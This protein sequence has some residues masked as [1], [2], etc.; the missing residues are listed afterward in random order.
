M[1]VLN[2]RANKDAMMGKQIVGGTF[3][4]WNGKDNHLPVGVSAGGSYKYRSVI[5]FSIDFSS[6]VS[7]TSATLTLYGNADGSNLHCFQ[8]AGLTSNL[9]VSRMTKDWLEGSYDNEGF[10]T[11]TLDYEWDNRYDSYTTTGQA[12]LAVVNQSG[13]G[14]AETIDVTDIVTSWFNG[15]NNYGFMVRNLKEDVGDDNYG[16]QFYSRQA[17]NS[18]YWPKLSIT[19]TTNTP[20]TE[21]T[22]NSPIN[23]DVVNTLIPTLSGTRNDTTDDYITSLALYVSGAGNR[24]LFS[25]STAYSDPG[26]G[27]LRFDNSTL[28]SATNMYL[29]KTD[30]DG[31]TVSA[32]SFVSTAKITIFSAS[33]SS[34]TSSFTR[35]TPVDMGT[36]IKI[37]LSGQLA[38]TK[39]TAGQSILTNGSADYTASMWSSGPITITGSPTTFS[40]LYGGAGVA[41]TPL[42]GNRYWA[43]QAATSDKASSWS[44]TSS[45]YYFKTNT[46]PDA[47]TTTITSYPNNDIT[48]Q[49]PSFTITHVDNDPD[50]TKAYSYRAIIER[51]SYVGSGVWSTDGG[52]DSLQVD[53]SATPYQ[54]ISVTSPV[55]SWGGSYRFKAAT[56]D[57]NGALGS[58]SPWKAFSLHYTAI[59]VD[60]FPSNGQT[61]SLVPTFTASRGSTTDTITSF[62]VQVYSSDLATQILNKTVNTSTYPGSITSGSQLS[63]TYDGAA[64]SA[65]TSYKWRIRA[66]ATPTNQAS[67]WSDWIT[68]TTAATGTPTITSPSG[69]GYANTS[70]SVTVTNGATSFTN[71]KY[72]IYPSTSTDS[73]PGTPLDTVTVG[74]F[75]GVTS[76]TV[77]Y[78]GS[79]LSYGTSYRIRAA[80]YVMSDW[81]PWAWSSFSTASSGIPTL[82][83][84]GGVVYSSTIPW[85]VTTTPTFTI[86]AY[87]SEVIDKMQ[88]RVFN[89]NAPTSPV[90][91]SSSYDV[92]NA[93]S[94]SL[95]LGSTTALSSAYPSALSP[96]NTYL[97][98]A[99]YVN[100][101]GYSGPFS[102]QKS[103]R[104]NAAPSIPINMYP[105]GNVAFSDTLEPTFYATF[106]DADPGDAP[107]GWYISVLGYNGGNWTTVA[108]KSRFSTNINAGINSYAWQSSDYGFQYDKEYRWTCYFSD[109]LLENGTVSSAQQFK[110]SSAPNGSFTSPSGGTVAGTPAT[111]NSVIPT[112]TWSYTGVA[113]QQSVKIEIDETDASGTVKNGTYKSTGDIIQTSNSYTFGSGY[114][115]SGK[116]YRIT[117]TVTNSDGIPDKEPDVRYILVDTNAPAAITGIGADA[118]NGYSI[119]I[120]WDQGVPKSG[121]TFN[122]YQIQRRLSGDVAWKT[123]GTTNKI[124][125]TSYNDYYAGNG[126]TYQY[127]IIMLVSA[128][129]TSSSVISSVEPDVPAI[130]TIDTDAW[131][132]IPANRSKEYIQELNVIDESH[133]KVIQQESF[134]T[135]GSARKLI[136]R[137]YV[138]GDEGSITCM[139][140]NQQ[141]T[142]PSNSS[143]TLNETIIGRR[144]LDYLTSNAGPHILKSPFGDVWEVQFE[145]PEYRWLP[146]GALEASMNWVETS[147]NA[148]GEI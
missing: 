92:T 106:S 75:S 36:W 52:W 137:G 29:S 109:Q 16:V 89:Q 100:T 22:L 35:G 105:A 7:I 23:G 67:D 96:G 115:A 65:S 135:L 87:G 70:F 56:V 18:D 129:G 15:S 104:V 41:A 20:P 63:Y 12:S 10:I 123:I 39:P 42:T 111:V 73:N 51:E 127:Q 77:T 55:L 90:W 43:W 93:S 4:G 9:R 44:P 37:P 113:S 79:A 25:T 122:S 116:Y 49:T 46:P 83:S 24:Y 19:Y 108:T 102:P 8:G 85:F 72:E 11:G 98:D 133:K 128:G 147:T 3:S 139:W 59:P 134:E 145:G 80:V 101:S 131:Y 142:S 94:A 148:S 117:L 1:A 95:T 34:Y 136:I 26:A 47:P 61:T 69:N 50:D 76:K 124:S 6:M 107:S 28:S 33:S 140:R 48:T 71:L 91:V 68:F 84:V 40:Q 27:Y 78:T 54:T 66:T 38:G 57:S 141:V 146:A 58:F 119:K 114:F 130:V 74:A 32:T 120:D 45:A 97:W 21:P 5:G 62:E 13:N 14:T 60:L 110:F 125:D 17:S 88:V 82:Y 86:N 103:F 81:T 121:Q 138:L 118:S 53:I 143:V 132:F 64:L 126:I 144:L 2:L 112:F 31:H 30:A 99:T